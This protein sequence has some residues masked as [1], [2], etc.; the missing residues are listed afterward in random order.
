MC[1]TLEFNINLYLVCFPRN[2]NKLIIKLIIQYKLCYS[3]ELG[4]S[5]HICERFRDGEKFLDQLIC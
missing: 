5:G 3:F 4:Y 1:L 2:N